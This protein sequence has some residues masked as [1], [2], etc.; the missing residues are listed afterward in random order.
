[1]DTLFADELAAIARE[2][3]ATLNNVALR[4][5]FAPA[6]MVEAA[7]AYPNAGGKALR[8]ALITWASG[9]LGGER[10]TAL[11]AGAATELYHTYTLVHD[12]IIDR[13]PVR[14]GNPSVHALMERVGREQFGLQDDAPHYGAS[15]A[16]LAGDAIQCWSIYLLTTLA[17]FGVP[18]TVM[19]QIIGRLQGQVGPAIVEGEV[20]DIQLPFLPVPEV[21]RD[22]ILRVITTKTSALFTFCA[23]TGGLLARGQEDDDVVRLA[24]FADNAGIAFQLQDDVLGLVA[25]A[26]TLGKPVGNDLRE[27]KRTMIIALGWE[28]AAEHERRQLQH[29]LGNPSA[30]PDDIAAATALLRRLGA[31]DDVQAMADHCLVDALH[32]LDELPANR[33]VDF[34]RELALKMVKRQK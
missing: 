28:R 8:P 19:L 12:D 23:W 2:V 33:C 16:I 30:S 10:Q 13:D 22:D 11:R 29:V 9:A 31:I 34:L 6:E 5:A 21:S 27:G 14:R 18:P 3:R 20:R 24:S 15:M 4:P 26:A 25:D 1:M 32:Y 7:L 17:D